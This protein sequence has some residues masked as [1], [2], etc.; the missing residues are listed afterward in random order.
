MVHAIRASI[1]AAALPLAVAPT[2]ADVCHPVH[3]QHHVS[4]HVAQ[5]KPAVTHQVAGVAVAIDQARMVSFSEPVKTV[6]LGNPTIADIS[7]ID[8][9]H[10]FLLGKTFGVTNMIALGPD[11]KQISNQQVVVL[12]D[13]EAVTVN[14]GADQYNYMCTPSHCETAPRPG[15]PQ[16]YVNNTEST[17]TS[18]ESSANGA[19]SSAPAQQASN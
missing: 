7:M 5:A 10:A 18:H 2:A 6:F 14:R 8:S 11:G 16:A 15:D 9:E 19:G 1:L 4:H 12:N 17:T 13:G 3:H